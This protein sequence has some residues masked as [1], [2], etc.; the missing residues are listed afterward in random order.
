MIASLLA[1]AS[2]FSAPT[3][4]WHALAPEIIIVIGINLVLGIDLMIEESKKGAIATVAGF[5][6]LAALVP[7][8]TLAVV[9]D[10]S[11]SMFDGRYVVDNYALILK[12]LFLL[13]AYVVI[14]MS[15]TELEEGGYY[16]GEFYVL[17]LCSVL[18][19]VMMASA[20]DLVSIFVALELLSIPAYMLAAVRK[21]DVKSNEAGV[22]YYLL[23]VFASAVLLYG[24]SLL[25]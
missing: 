13:I 12:A 14:L 7:V 9:G 24:M 11:R 3:I 4:D 25:Y 16:Q 5:V 8:V 15:Q 1:Q 21:R 18:G 6:M 19:M 10:D 17:M 23:G 20:R 22:K 2:V